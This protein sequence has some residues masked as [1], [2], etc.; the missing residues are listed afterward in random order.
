MINSTNRHS[1]IVEAAVNISIQRR[2]PCDSDV[3]INAAKRN[4]E[5]FPYFDAIGITDQEVLEMADKIYGATTLPSTLS[6][7]Q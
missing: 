5:I 3:A 2:W 6:E 4:R 1:L 7:D